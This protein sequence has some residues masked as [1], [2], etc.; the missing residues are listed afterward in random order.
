MKQQTIY[1]RIILPLPHS[2]LYRMHALLMKHL[3]CLYVKSP[4]AV[5]S[6]IFEGFVGF[7]R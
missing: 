7:Y 6:D 5:R 4:V 2:I 3:I 1:A